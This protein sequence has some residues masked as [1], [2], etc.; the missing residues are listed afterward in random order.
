MRTPSDETLTATPERSCI[1]TRE[2]ASPAALVRLALAPDGRVLPDVR[3]KAPGRG[4]WIGVDR[5][6][7]EQALA[8]GK[9]RGALARAFK[10][11]E[12]TVSDELPALIEAAL[13]RNALD[14]LGLESRGGSVLTGS[15]RIETA[16]RSGKLHA[17]YHAADASDDGRRKLAQAWRVGTDREGSD[18]RGLALPVARPILS[19][20]LGRENVVHVGVIDRAAAK[21]LSEALDRWLHFIGPDL[22]TAPCATAAQGASAPG[23]AGTTAPAV[24]LHEEFE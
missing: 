7:L 20:A 3:A 9:L 13:E 22:N 24:R 21:R 2:R 15:E 16:A 10:T 5:A 17:L 4:A 18:L 19:L 12:F 14:R 11:G 6:S 8:K 1:L 23:I